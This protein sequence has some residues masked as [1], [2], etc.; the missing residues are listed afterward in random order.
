MRA[1]VY[2]GPG[3]IALENRPNPELAAPTD[4]IVRLTAASICGTDLH[5]LHGDV[6]AIPDGR[7]LG[8]EGVGIVEA[9]G[10]EVQDFRCGDRVLISLNTSCGRCDFCRRRM[11]SHC[12][13]G[14]WILGNSIDGTQAELVRIP[15]A[16]NGLYHLGPVIADEAA[17]LLSC[18]FPTSL[19][20]GV[21]AAEVKPGDRVAIVGAGPVGLA[22]LM[23][24][25]L[26]SPAMTVMVDLD[27][28]RLETALSLGATHVVDSS[29]SDAAEK[30]L[31]LTQGQGFDV[32]V[33]AAGQSATFDLCQSILAPGGHLANVGVHG[34]PVCLHLERLWATNITLTTRLVDA[35]TTP[36]LLAM[37]GSGRLDPHRLVSHR[38][39][40]SDILQAY[41]TFGH[42]AQ[43][44]AVKVVLLSSS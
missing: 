3:K 10:T 29:G 5:I 41:E 6:P 37:V 16:D 15:F 32:A 23:A 2:H 8:H 25:Q 12:R 34:G 42:A 26:S 22:T 21:M 17:V 28:H 7:I 40:F 14:G 39:G 44:Q 18:C 36:T 35:Y 27:S 43:H 11:P 24:C 33:E 38:F 30:I 4:A 1:L 13:Q 20:C 19:E 31:A 9:V